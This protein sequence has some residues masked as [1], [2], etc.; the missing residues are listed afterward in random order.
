MGNPRG[1][2]D[3]LGSP[4]VNFGSSLRCWNHLL[5]PGQLLWV[6]EPMEPK[7]FLDSIVRRSSAN[8]PELRS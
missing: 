6:V 7:V 2:S 8:D 5:L 4:R 3:E 1:S